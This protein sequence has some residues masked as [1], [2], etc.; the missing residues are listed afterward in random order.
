LQSGVI[1][2]EKSKQTAREN[3]G[4]K[5]RRTGIVAFFRETVHELKRVQW[6]K[7]KEVISYTTA[8][9]LTCV[10]LGLLVWGFDIGVAKVLSLIGLI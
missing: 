7:R 9:L 8:A 1:Y 2:L 6:P 10:I 4:T 3:T 5:Q